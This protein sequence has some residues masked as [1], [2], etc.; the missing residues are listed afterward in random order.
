V[1]DVGSDMGIIPT[2]FKGLGRINLIFMPFRLI[3]VG[4]LSLFNSPLSL[5]KWKIMLSHLTVS[6]FTLVD[7]LEIEL[8][9]GMT[10]V[11]GETGAGKSIMLDALGLALGDRSEA[12][13]IG[14]HGEK[15]EIHAT[16]DLK[17][18]Q[19]ALDWL[20][21]RE[22]G[23]DQQEC[24]LRRV[25][26]KDGR[27]RGYINGTP[28]T[29]N[30]MKTLGEHLIDIHSQ[31]EHQSLLKKETHRRLLDEFAGVIS[32][33][34][35]VST[36]FLAYQENLDRLKTLISSNADQAAR[37]QLLSYQA[38]ELEQLNIAAGETEKLEKEQKRLASAESIL[39]SCHQVLD[40]CNTNGGVVAHLSKSA[41]LM[42]DMQLDEIKPITE[43]LNSG[44]IQVEEAILDL[45]RFSSDFNMDPARLADVE[46]RLTL[47]YDL[48]RKHRIESSGI[49][50]L[51]ADIQ[52]ELSTLGNIDQ[53][54][55]DCEGQLK[56]LKS[57]YFVAAKK[58]SAARM[59]AAKKLHRR[60]SDQLG[61]LGMGGASF[62]ISLSPLAEH[63]PNAKGMEDIEFL[64]STNP[65]Q[66]AK[67][68]NKIASGGE[69]SRISLA[70][71]VVTADTSKVPTLVFDEVDVGIGGGIAEVVGALLREL[72]EKAQIICVTHLPQVAAQGHQHLKV[73]KHEED[74]LVKTEVA[75]LG[76]TGKIAEI[77]RMLGGIE[78]TDQS[79]AHAKE[80]Y[81]SAQA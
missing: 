45:E 30:D 60:V 19:A 11:S 35:K 54:I 24:L 71:Q 46:D 9:P 14:N 75:E 28:S 48:C 56:Q 59:K 78:I 2:S 26:G 37:L 63:S 76:V 44:K 42:E 72:G 49:E 43:L 66:S 7:Q 21:E 25:L 64:I 23:T 62:E 5:I 68:L 55:V 57:K 22:L 16:F 12:G 8:S 47:I 27:S 41:K 17:D 53:E 10:V 52:S 31:H 32:D 61:E 33:A 80:M 39:Q 81:Q 4:A 40:F 67:S 69:L 6:N 20:K 34:N 13:T 29:V 36:L 77:A 50:K 65:G 1:F 73:T 15:A 70:I 79:L 38:K 51:T 18:N 74:K 58:L 3:A